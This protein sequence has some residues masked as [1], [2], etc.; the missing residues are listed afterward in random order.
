M[1]VFTTLAIV[2]IILHRLLLW[3]S[4]LVGS[5]DQ[6][7][8]RRYC[9]GVKP[10][11]RLKAR[12]K[13]DCEENRHTEAV[14]AID[15]S[16]AAIIAFAHSR[17]LWLGSSRCIGLVLASR[18]HGNLAAAIMRARQTQAVLRL[19]TIELFFGRSITERLCKLIQRW[20]GRD[21]IN[22]FTCSEKAYHV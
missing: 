8:C 15:V 21:P 7:R 1:R 16:P 14:S 2:L 12:V 3:E 22:S 20:Y 19:G 6:R 18:S 10:V 17:R 4:L 5:A 13:L 11:A 9:P